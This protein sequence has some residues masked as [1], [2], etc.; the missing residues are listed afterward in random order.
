[1]TRFDSTVICAHPSS[2]PLDP[3][4][5]ARPGL[6]R[7]APPVCRCRC[8]QHGGLRRSVRRPRTGAR[9]LPG[10]RGGHRAV[11]PGQHG[12]SPRHGRR[13]PPWAG[14]PASESLTSTAL[15][16]VSLTFTTGAVAVTRALGLTTLAPHAL[17]GDG[18]Q[19]RGGRHPVR[20]LAHLGV[21]SRVRNPAVGPAR[22]TRS[23][24]LAAG[25]DGWVHAD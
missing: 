8:G 18:G 12:R 3:R 2:P 7:R 24:H 20:H 17:C 25:A 13:R 21:P 9:E 23:R 15:F 16:G 14:P 11:Q 5:C 22:Y 6:R 4:R 1:M 10:Q 19:R